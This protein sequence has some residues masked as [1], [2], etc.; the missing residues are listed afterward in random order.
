MYR[1]LERH[2]M[3]LWNQDWE[4]YGESLQLALGG[5][6][7][8]DSGLEETEELTAIEYVQLMRDTLAATTFEID[9]QAV[10]RNIE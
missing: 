5:A 4:E 9:D 8:T 10:N 6:G 7:V 2:Q 1:K 3:G